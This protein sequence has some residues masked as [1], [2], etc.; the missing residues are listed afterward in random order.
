M[1][2]RLPEL[3]KEFGYTQQQLADLAEVSRQTIIAI[4]A[5]KF[6]PSVS[7]A[8]RLSHIFHKTIEELFIYSGSEP[9]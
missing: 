2:N 4:E 5:G 9:K 6:N 1:K 8:F 3:R 7:L